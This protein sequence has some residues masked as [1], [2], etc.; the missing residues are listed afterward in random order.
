MS[1]NPVA[2]ALRARRSV[3]HFTDEALARETITA[4]LDEATWAPSGG[5]DQPWG[6]VALSPEPARALRDRYEMR[7]WH[8]LAPKMA[9]IVERHTGPAPPAA[10]LDRVLDK[11]ASE[12]RS[13]GAPWL[14]LVH[15][16]AHLENEASRLREFHA[17]LAA[18][19]PPDELP[20]LAEIETMLGPVHEGVIAASI[21][22][23][24]YAITLA[25]HARGL[26]T[27][28]QHN[29][30]LFRDALAGELELPRD[31]AFAAGVLVGRADADDPVVKRAEARA[32]RRPLDVRY[33]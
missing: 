32:S 8:A 11:L 26:A 29:W 30:L 1:T 13:R 4:V 5:D 28:I 17:A 15:G 9:S 31:R 25:A 22:G 12:A 16:P 20:T 19:V 33:R 3:R 14:L 24:V 21:A 2:D 27:C 18:R 23:F 7:A 10:I 6:V